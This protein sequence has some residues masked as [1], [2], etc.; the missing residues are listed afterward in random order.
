MKTIF[1]LSILLLLCSSTLYAQHPDSLLTAQEMKDD[2]DSLLQTIIASHPMPGGFSSQL[3]IETAFH[4]AI[5]K[6]ETENSILDFSK[7]VA[8][9]MFNMRDS[10]SGLDYGQLQQM[11]FIRSGFFLPLNCF[12]SDQGIYI[13]NDWEEK[14]PRG[15]RIVSIN[16]IDAY[17]LYNISRH[18]ACIEG[19]AESASEQI[20]AAIFP[21]IASL[22]AYA[23]SSNTVDVIRYDSIERESFQ[24]K[25]YSKKEYAKQK[26]IRSALLEN[27]V[28]NFEF[29][30]K[31]THAVLS[32]RTFAPPNSRY[33]S[34]FIKRAFKTM[35]QSNCDTLLLD[36]RDNGGG[37]SSWVEYLYSFLDRN[38]HNTPNNVISKNSTLA[39]KR[40]KPLTRKFSKFVL[41]TFFKKNEDV[42][43]FLKI[44][45]LPYGKLDTTF[46]HD[47]TIQEKE[48]IYKGKC[49]L[50]INGLT[51]SAG[52]D[53]TN[54]FRSKRRGTIVGEPCLGPVSGTWGNPA[55]YTL[56]NS[57]L[58][59]SIATIRYN[60]NNTFKYE[61][62]AIQPDFVIHST[63][64]GILEKRDEVIE[65]IL[66]G[67]K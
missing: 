62:G 20:A 10:H 44:A 23:D 37:S 12:V 5:N 21:I 6:I 39:L 50:L 8:D 3:S 57:K 53:F 28:V 1:L 33:Y 46:F 32:V 41:R 24:L 4:D 58:R 65:F 16:G 30:E 47:K 31:K 34:R 38:G 7:I 25:G 63:P 36:L 29:N 56:P 54:T 18:Y 40:A 59:V 35:A 60:Y 64:K 45:D 66:G 15:S 49:F 67:M 27:K 17:N 11:S 19:Y 48:L 42:A 55:I 2:L 51:A 52:V 9:L 61:T 26:K 14:L 43:S 22:Y 13:L